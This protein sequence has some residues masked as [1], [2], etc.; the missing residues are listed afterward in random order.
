[1]SKLKGNAF[2]RNDTMSDID[3][4]G[5]LPKIGD[6]PA[7]ENNFILSE[8]DSQTIDEESKTKLIQLLKRE[9]A[10]TTS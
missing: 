6:G 5:Q 1:M 4:L 10:T 3:Y 9:E 8:D 2:F 7:T